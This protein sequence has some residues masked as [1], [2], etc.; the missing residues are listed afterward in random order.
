MKNT[1]ILKKWRWAILLVSM[2]GIWYVL[3]CFFGKT[4]RA[5]II[6]EDRVLSNGPYCGV[7]VYVMND[8]TCT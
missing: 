1:T 2:L 7:K 3:L 5:V 6:F 4:G 8:G